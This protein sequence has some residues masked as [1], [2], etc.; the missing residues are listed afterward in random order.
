MNEFKIFKSKIL[1]KYHKIEFAEDSCIDDLTLTF[2]NSFQTEFYFV[3]T[4]SKSLEFASIGACLNNAPKNQYFWLTDIDIID[5]EENDVNLITEFIIET[6]DIILQHKTRIT[7]KKTLLTQKFIL[8][9]C[10]NGKWIK[11]SQRSG[12]R[13]TNLSFPEF[14]GRKKMYE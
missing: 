2:S 9:Y 13:Y 5:S 4:I 3:L 11:F 7:Q 10:V 1:E 14:K 6:L 8:D 12:L